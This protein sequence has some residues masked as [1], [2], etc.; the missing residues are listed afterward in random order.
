MRTIRRRALLPALLALL[1][2]VGLLP[3]PAAAQPGL[4]EGAEV[5]PD[6]EIIGGTRADPHEDPFQVAL[7]FHD[8]QDRWRAQF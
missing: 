8:V 4:P 2:G 3:P 5:N 6:A 1:A 7:L